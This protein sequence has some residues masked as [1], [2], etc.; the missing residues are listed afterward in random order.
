MATKQRDMVS[1][2]FLVLS[3]DIP[4]AVELTEHS[5]EYVGA[6]TSPA[7]RRFMVGVYGSHSKQ[8]AL[9]VA[10][11]W[12]QQHQG[13][14]KKG[15]NR[16]LM[17]DTNYRVDNYQLTRDQIRRDTLA[18]T[19]WMHLERLSAALR[20]EIKDE[21]LSWIRKDVGAAKADSMEDESLLDI[22]YHYPRYVVKM[23]QRDPSIVATIHP[24][25]LAL[26]PTV[27]LM[28]ATVRYEP[29][30]F[31]GAHLRFLADIPITV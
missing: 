6:D 24:V 1:L 28:V 12:T 5:L 3:R 22:A 21:W 2:S 7:S 31:V 10:A 30:R 16:V 27:K 15:P 19:G 18:Q 14:Q 13:T 17:L 26:D 25:Q 8:V 20:D 23:M 29:D 9:T 11:K 4:A